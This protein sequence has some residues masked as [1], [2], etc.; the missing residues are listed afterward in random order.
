VSRVPALPDGLT[1]PEAAD[2]WRITVPEPEAAVACACLGLEAP[3]DARLGALAAAAFGPT[4]ES[5]EVGFVLTLGS[6]DGHGRLAP[7]EADPEDER[8]LMAAAAALSTPRLAL[9]AG[10][11]GTHAL[12]WA[13]GSLDLA[14]APWGGAVGRDLAACL[15]EGDGEPLLRRLVDDSVNLLGAHPANRR[16]A[17]EGLPPAN[18]LWPWEP[19]RG[20][21]PQALWLGQ[22]PPP[23]VETSDWQVLGAARAAGLTGR[24]GSAVRVEP[25]PGDG[26]PDPDERGYLARADWEQGWLSQPASVRGQAWAAP[27]GGA[28]WA[29]GLDAGSPWH[30]EVAHDPD[31]PAAP[32][33]AWVA[34]CLASGARAR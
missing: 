34:L 15:P 32:L 1:G 6:V 31:A 23:A 22:S 21:A 11:G 2:G 24:S 30:P 12:V 13:R 10:S 20:F 18:V 5:R 26:S 14:C 4:L 16:R 27:E 8:D 25:G 33:A 7:C 28:A 19:G 17:E 29:L 3:P 9:R